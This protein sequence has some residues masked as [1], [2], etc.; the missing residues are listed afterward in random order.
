MGT[1][2]QGANAT[3]A[4]HRTVPLFPIQTLLGK[5]KAKEEGGLGLSPTLLQVTVFFLDKKPKL[6]SIFHM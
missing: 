5:G 1:S 2:L 6:E 3:L 4:L